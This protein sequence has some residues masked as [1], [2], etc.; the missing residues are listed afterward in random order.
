MEDVADFFSLFVM[1]TLAFICPILADRIPRHIVPETV[2]LLLLGAAFG[3]YGLGLIQT[4]DVIGFL[5]ELGCGFLF[6]LAGREIEPSMLMGHEGRRGLAAWGISFAIAII[7]SALLPNVQFGSTTAW[8]IA[9]MLTTT[10]I[11]T[12]M[13]IL[14]ERGLIGTPLGNSVVSYGTWGEICPVLAIVMLLSA[15]AAWQSAAIL[16]GLVLL[17]VIIAAQGA[18]AKRRG[19][20][21]YRVLVEKANGTAQTM[22]RLT[23]FLLI[24]LVTVS[25]VFDVDIVLGAFAAGFVLDYLVPKDEEGLDQ[26]LNGMG[27]G[28]F[29]PVFFIYSGS[30]IDVGAVASNPVLLVVFILA[31]LLVRSVPVFVIARTDRKNPN[32][33]SA[34]ACASVAV[35]CATALPLIV[36]VTTIAVSSGAMSQRIASVLVAAGAVT[37][38]LMPLLGQLAMRAAGAWELDVSSLTQGS[39]QAATE[40][41]DV[42]ARAAASPEEPVVERLHERHAARIALRMHIEG[43]IDSGDT[44]EAIAHYLAEELHFEDDEQRVHAVEK[45]IERL[46]SAHRR[47]L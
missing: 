10:A 44:P 16:V 1:V 11:G 45:R 3:P 9:I 43:M 5:S 47:M 20:R 14:D 32:R 28:F 29:I 19:S 36:A 13:P 27:Y 4:N 24:M 42:A 26:K 37:V 18:A 30:K 12:L 34:R 25:A 35:Y 33:L 8:A 39:P 23:L 21:V 31:L 2:F 17:C 7:V 22:V 40:G 46:Q 15:R 38:F 6:L 41:A